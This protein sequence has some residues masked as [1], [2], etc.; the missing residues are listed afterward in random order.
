MLPLIVALFIHLD[1]FP[2]M[3]D[4][5]IGRYATEREC[6]LAKD[7]LHESHPSIYFHWSCSTV[8]T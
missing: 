8:N 3:P 1:R 6:L 2:A 5:Q 7:E 4:I